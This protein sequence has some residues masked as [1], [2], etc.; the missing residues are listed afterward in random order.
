MKKS[1]L[2]SAALYCWATLQHMVCAFHSA[3]DEKDAGNIFIINLLFCRNAL[4][5]QFLY[6][7]PPYLLYSEN[8]SKGFINAIFHLPSA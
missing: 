6:H 7:I 5:R 1:E 2:S 3:K 8:V 4:L